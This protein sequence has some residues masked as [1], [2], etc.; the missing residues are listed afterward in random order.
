[1][2]TSYYV[3]GK[4]PPIGQWRRLMT[5]FGKKASHWPVR[6]SYNI[7]AKRFPLPRKD[8]LWC[9]WQYVSLWPMRMSYDVI[10][11]VLHIDLWRHLLMS[12]AKCFA[13]AF[14]DSI[15]YIG[16]FD[17][18][19]RRMIHWQSLRFRMTSLAKCFPLARGRHMMSL[20]KCFPLAYEDI[21]LSSVNF[22]F[23]C[24]HTEQISHVNIFLVVF[25]LILS[26]PN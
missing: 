6:T 16:K 7:L 13:L 26:P 19:G 22:L 11:K 8:V 2:I 21:I 5:S 12:L 14:G 10:G 17:L 1:M 3:I 9:H 15:W 20:V 18:W 24:S 4:I 25:I 23:I